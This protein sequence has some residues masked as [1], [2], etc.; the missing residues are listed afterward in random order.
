MKHLFGFSASIYHPSPMLIWIF[1]T[2]G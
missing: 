2:Q 1:A